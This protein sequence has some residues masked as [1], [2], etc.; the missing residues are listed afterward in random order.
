M[1]LTSLL[2]LLILL[3]SPLHPIFPIILLLSSHLLSYFLLSFSSSFLSPSLLV[4]PLLAAFA[5]LVFPVLASTT[6]YILLVILSSLLLLSSNQS[7][8]CGKLTT[9]FPKLHST[10][11][12]QSHLFLSSLYTTGS[13]YLSLWY[14]ILAS[15]C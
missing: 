5:T 6:F 9:A 11:V 10:F 13:K 14:F 4:S 7:Q 8:N 3:L 12:L 1:V 15:P 2:P